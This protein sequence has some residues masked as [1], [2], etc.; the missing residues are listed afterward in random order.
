MQT[1]NFQC[2][3]CGNLMA[4][5]LEYLGQ[6]VRCPHCQQVV[7]APATDQPAPEAPQP[8]P[9]PEP[10]FSASHE[11]EDIFNQNRESDDALF[12]SAQGPGLEIPVEPIPLPP[13]PIAGVGNGEW[14][15]GNGEG[16]SVGE[17]ATNASAFPQ[18][19]QGQQSTEAFFSSPGTT[20]DAAASPSAFTNE[21]EQST[22][23]RRPRD[24][25]N[26]INWFIPLV[27]I[28]LVLYSVLATAVAG[29]LYLRLSSSPPNPFDRFPDLEGDNPGVRKDKRVS[30]SFTRRQVTAPLPAHLKVKLGETL[31]IGDL[32][33]TPYK[34]ERRKVALFTEG[35]EQ[36]EQGPHDALVLNLKLKN[37]ASDYAFTPLDNYFDRS[38]KAGN[39]NS[40][41]LTLLQAGQ[42]TFFGGPAKWYP[43]KRD[44]NRRERRDWLEGRKN[45]DPEGLAPGES[46]KSIVCTD[47]WDP[48]IARY[49]FGVDTEGQQVGKPY[50]GTLL[51]RV[52]VR[53]GLVPWKG[54]EL[55]ATAVIGVE[56]TDKEYSTS[57]N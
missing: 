28:P 57:T 5:A 17:E 48:A 3:H 9:L 54:R 29:Y 6:Q 21:G 14:G 35:A 23:A 13:A 2:G 18:A 46:M 52:Q 38:W 49:L 51:W 27:F 32:E 56:F 8:Q 34:V 36:S 16:R 25:A 44:V 22:I 40:T 45:G 15:M 37:L 24:S 10:P 7:I 43:L 55:P 42:E 12:G 41:P 19:D 31:Q 50:R 20:S 1:V 30:F 11:S 53:R 39:D 47:A 33:V 26:R 4:V